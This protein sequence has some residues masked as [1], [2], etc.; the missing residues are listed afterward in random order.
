MRS[1]R[2]AQEHGE[3]A[4]LTQIMI[5]ITRGQMPQDFTNYALLRIPRPPGPSKGGFRFTAYPDRPASE[6]CRDY[7]ALCRRFADDFERDHSH[8]L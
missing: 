6:I 2:V 1:E 3:G 4:G 8:L 5:P 7:L